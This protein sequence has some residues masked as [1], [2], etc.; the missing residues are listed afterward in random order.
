MD[1]PIEK[2]K[3]PPKR[4]ILYSSIGLFVLII[5]YLLIFQAGGSTLNVEKERLTISTVT[6]GPFQEFIPIIGNVLP[7][8]TIYLDAVIGG[9][10]EKLY[11]EAGAQVKEGDKILL[12]S[13]TNLLMTLL[14]NEAQI[15]R[16]SNDLRAT[17][18]QLERNRLDLKRQ[19]T[20]ADYFLKRIKRRYE[21]NE[22][23][24]KEKYIS[25]QEFDDFK[26]EYEYQ[27][28]NRELTIESQEKDLKFSEEQV[29]QL[30]ASVTQM[31]TNLALLKSQLENLTIKAP[32]T[33]HLT[34]LLAEVGQSKAQGE[35]LGQIDDISGFKA[36]A[37]ID[38]HYINRV[39][40][41]K[42][43]Q[44][45]FSGNTYD[46][47]ISKIYP[48][49]RDGRF[50]VDME[51]MGKH[52]EGIRRG[53][54]LHI[55]LQLS[56]VSQAILVA[57]GGFYQ[58]TGGNWAYV[59]D[60]SGKYAVKKQ[61]RLG[62]QNPEFFEVMEGLNPGEKVITSSYENYGDMDRLVLK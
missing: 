36:R 24:F 4:I 44:F 8:R 43:G 34:S 39:E 33:G 25:K 21:R 52:A 27:K 53:Q 29:K 31:E 35:R 37:P 55:R 5:G 47:K 1:K 16:A 14:N 59:I 7:H 57:R 42:V 30:E 38:E 10:V 12:L 51:F 22:V 20:E 58:T 45:D 15:N 19:R 56:D 23:L 26:D 62:R 11:L 49:V 3:W 40:I 60:S 41:G 32:I 54:S 6:K 50:E 48:E 17:R 2:K 18:L 28:K 61:I 13:N 46:L 9:S